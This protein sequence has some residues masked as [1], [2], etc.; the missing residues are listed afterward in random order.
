M[1]VKVKQKEAGLFPGGIERA[2]AMPGLVVWECNSSTWQPRKR[3]GESEDN[4]GYSVRPCPEKLEKK[5]RKRSCH[6]LLGLCCA[7]SVENDM[8]VVPSYDF[9]CDSRGANEKA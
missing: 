4:T 7:F 8:C 5:R 2:A 6:Q 1:K 9:K 3:D